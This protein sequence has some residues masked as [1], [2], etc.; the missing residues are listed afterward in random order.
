M[1]KSSASRSYEEGFRQ[2]MT[3]QDLCFLKALHGYCADS[4]PQGNKIRVRVTSK[5]IVA[6]PRST[7]D[8]KTKVICEDGEKL[9]DLKPILQL[10][11]SGLMRK[12]N[13]EGKR[14][15]NSYSTPS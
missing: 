11:S 5:E 1:F 6:G 12:F 3:R 2:E 13:A 7:S 4:G 8:A 10:K 9:T 15:S 14:N